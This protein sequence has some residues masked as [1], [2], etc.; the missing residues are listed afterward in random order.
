MEEETTAP[1]PT[2]PQYERYRQAEGFLVGEVIGKSFSVWARKLATLLLIMVIVYSPLVVYK[3]VQVVGE[4]FPTEIFDPEADEPELRNDVMWRMLGESAGAI[5]LGFVAQAAVIYAVLQELRG[6]RVSVGESLRVGM[7]RILPVLG[8]ALATGICIGFVPVLA[9]SLP[10]SLG[11]SILLLPLVPLAVAWYLYFWCTLWV[12]VPAVVVERT[13]V[14]G[15]LGRSAKLAYGDK[16]RILGILL[17][18]FAIQV[19]ARFVTG[20]ATMASLKV[21]IVLELATALLVGALSAT[22]AAVG[23]RDLRRA[24]EGVGVEDLLKVFA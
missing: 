1:R 19:G 14:F 24:K 23:Y 13:G 15:A 17:I 4:P 6:E 5:L 7:A 18:L 20:A 21:G 3:A 2:R 12:A 8:V 11:A 9:V 22:V 16:W 10:L